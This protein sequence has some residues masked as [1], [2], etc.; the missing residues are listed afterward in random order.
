MLVVCKGNY[1]RHKCAISSEAKV[2]ENCW[3]VGLSQLPQESQAIRQLVVSIATDSE[4]LACIDPPEPGFFDGPSDL[5]VIGYA[6][7]RPRVWR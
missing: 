7:F 3:N 4:G 2:Y 1:A 6:P 5:V